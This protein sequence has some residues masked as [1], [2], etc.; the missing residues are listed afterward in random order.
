MGI[1]NCNIAF[2]VLTHE[3]Y[4]DTSGAARKVDGCFK[5]RL[6]ELGG[7]DTVCD[8]AA[9][10]LCNLQD[11]LE[12]EETEQSKRNRDFKALEKC[13][14]NGG[15]GMLLR[16][17]RVIENVTFLSELNQRHLLE[18]RLPRRKRDAPLSFIGLVTSTIK[19]LS[20]RD[21][22]HLVNKH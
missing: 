14:K 9:G 6:R 4:A 17:L 8:L 15:V 19:M 10:C 16:C 3:L 21:E 11:A 13:E 1:K 22:L 7:L 2:F 12:G 20:G 5:E 18:L